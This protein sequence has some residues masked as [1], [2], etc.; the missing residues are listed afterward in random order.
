MKKWALVIEA[1]RIWVGTQLVCI[2]MKLHDSN[3]V[4]HPFGICRFANT[5]LKLS[6][7]KVLT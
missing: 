1:Q 6:V 2:H 5:A 4:T 7:T 3:K